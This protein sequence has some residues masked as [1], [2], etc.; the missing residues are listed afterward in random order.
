MDRG[1]SGS[2]GLATLCIV[3]LG[4]QGCMWRLIPELRE[5]RR[6]LAA[7]PHWHS[8]QGRSEGHS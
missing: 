1:T 6:V 7:S 4:A 8:K 3:W 2:L 5:T